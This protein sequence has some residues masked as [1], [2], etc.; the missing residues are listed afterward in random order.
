[1]KFWNGLENIE[2]WHRDGQAAQAV[3]LPPGDGAD[4][5]DQGAGEDEDEEDDTSTHTH[6][7]R[8]PIPFTTWQPRFIHHSYAL[9]PP[10]HSR[11]QKKRTGHGTIGSSIFTRSISHCK[12]HMTWHAA[13]LFPHAR[14]AS[15]IV[16][17]VLVSSPRVRPVLSSWRLGRAA[18][19]SIVSFHYYCTLFSSFLPFYF[20][21]A[22][23]LCYHI[24]YSLYYF[25]RMCVCAYFC[26]HLCP[27]ILILPCVLPT[28]SSLLALEV[29]GRRVLLPFLGRTL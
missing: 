2:H 13:A 6:S 19:P 17:S 3:L 11:T 7:H 5:D 1:M 27:A 25:V 12:S 16:I 10:T 24:P 22:C 9:P 4:A 20:V 18:P 26:Y 15:C 8:H 23:S 21:F 28:L 14:R 29:V